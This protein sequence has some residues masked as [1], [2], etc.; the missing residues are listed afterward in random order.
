MLTLALNIFR[1]SDDP[2]FR[3]GYDSLGANCYYNHIY[4]ELVYLDNLCRN[5]PVEEF[6]KAV[7]LQST[8]Q[9][10]D[11]N[12]INMFNVGVTL[13]ELPEYPVGCLVIEPNDNVTDISE[14][15]ESV[16]N[17]AGMILSHLIEK[18]VPH[19]MLIS[20]N[21]CTVYI[22]LRSF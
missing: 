6:P 2:N 4:F 13:S 9:H 12:E 15:T 22:F 1:I 20:N 5:L 10:K 7:I 17:V 19:S 21:G 11:E 8:L 18:N 16:G 14:I 3:L